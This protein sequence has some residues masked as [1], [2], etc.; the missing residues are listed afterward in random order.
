L[1]SANTRGVALGD[2]NRDSQLDAVV[3]NYLSVDTV[4]LNRTPAGGDPVLVADSS[5]QFSATN[6][7]NVALGDLDGDGDLDAFFNVIDGTFRVFLNDGQGHFVVPPLTFGTSG[8]P[9]ND[10]LALGDV[11]GDGD[12]DAVVGTGAGAKIWLNQQ[13]PPPPPPVAK[14]VSSPEPGSEINLGSVTHA[15]NFRDVGRFLDIGNDGDKP[16]TIIAVNI[17]STSDRFS[18]FPLDA[19]GFG[20]TGENPIGHKVD[21]GSG[22][23]LAKGAHLYVLV[24]YGTSVD[25]SD[26]QGLKEGTLEVRSDDPNNP[27]VQYPLKCYVAPEFTSPELEI[28]ISYLFGLSPTGASMRTATLAA[29]PATC[30]DTVTLGIDQGA[31]HSLSVQVPDAFGGGTMEVSDFEGSLTISLQPIPADTNNCVINVAGGTFT[32]PSLTLPSGVATGPNTLT[33]GPAEQSEGRLD[34]TTGSFTATATG[35]IV[36][37]LFPEGVAIIG[38]Y[39]GTADIAAGVVNVQ[40]HTW[41]FIP[42]GTASDTQPPVITINIPEHGAKFLLNQIVAANY[43][44]EDPSGVAQCAGPVPSGSPIDTTSVGSKSFIVAATDTAGNTTTSTHN[45]QVIYDY[46]GFFQPVDN[47]PTVNAVKAGQSI[48]IKFSLG[49]NQGLAI[50][51]PTSQGIACDTT[52]PVSDLEETATAGS[53]GLSYDSTLDQYIY[54]W[55]T[56]KSWT[57]TCRQFVLKLTD[58]TE[59]VANFAFK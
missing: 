36:N 32:S 46:N 12:L 48:P 25:D 53:S 41:D 23:V 5:Q 59:H 44:C 28:M 58:E 47:L 34:L 4:F 35:T 54:T 19:Y 57:G 50:G 51:T 3:A 40:S 43:T 13:A 24:E 7:F 33:F 52:A 17:L 1:D 14:Y 8:G 15:K 56:D 22:Y 2:V 30:N 10:A 55:K 20:S 6:S 45:Y 29:S 49:G 31:P 42:A 26:P 27:V 37:D 39:S 11:D 16:L 18:Y 9:I 38:F 21:L